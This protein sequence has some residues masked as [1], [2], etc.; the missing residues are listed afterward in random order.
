[1]RYEYDTDKDR[2]KEPKRVCIPELNCSEA[3]NAGR[4][5][6]ASAGSYKLEELVIWT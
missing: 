3:I 1:M 5:S 2:P 4:E 6:S